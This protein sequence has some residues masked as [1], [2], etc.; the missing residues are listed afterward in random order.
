MTGF[1][2]SGMCVH[3]INIWYDEVKCCIIGYSLLL[4][5]KAETSEALKKE[6]KDYQHNSVYVIKETLL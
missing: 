6:Y 1:Y 3:F 5:Q 2:L 4:E